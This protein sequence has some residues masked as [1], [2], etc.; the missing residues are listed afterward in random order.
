MLCCIR[1]FLKISINIF[2]SYKD[3]CKFFLCMRNK[4]ETSVHL[5]KQS[6]KL[7]LAS[8][9]IY[10]APILTA[11]AMVSF[12]IIWLFLFGSVVSAAPPAK[13]QTF[14]L[15]DL[16]PHHLFPYFKWYQIVMLI[17]NTE[18]ILACHYRVVFL[19]FLFVFQPEVAFSDR[20]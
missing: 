14:I 15:T 10:L 6:S 8:P 17:W 16:K 5:I 11:V 13:N 3:F 12:W 2:L 9:C 7:L 1:Y 20:K 19:N 4:T 18:F